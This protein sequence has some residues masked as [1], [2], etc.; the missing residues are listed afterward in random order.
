MFVLLMA[1]VIW[2]TVNNRAPA[3]LALAGFGSTNPAA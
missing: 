2:A 1:F 3:Y